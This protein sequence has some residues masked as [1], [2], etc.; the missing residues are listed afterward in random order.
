VLCAAPLLSSSLS[1]IDFC[2]TDPVQP[3][4]TPPQICT[5]TLAGK[6][7]VAPFQALSLDDINP[8][9]GV[10]YFGGSLVTLIGKRFH[11]DARLFVSGEEIFGV[12][13]TIPSAS[14][15]IDRIALCVVRCP[16]ICDH[17]DWFV[18]VPVRPAQSVTTLSFITVGNPNITKNQYVP[19]KVENPIPN[20]TTT[21]DYDIHNGLLYLTVQKCR[22]IDTSKNLYE[23]F[24]GR[25]CTACPTGAECAGDDRLWPMPGYW[26]PNERTPPSQCLVFEACPGA[27]GTYPEFPITYVSKYTAA[28]SSSLDAAPLTCTRAIPC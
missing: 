22:L 27:L 19:V 14:V 15:R 11:A 1:V 18:S 26:S 6:V 28:L 12:N 3:P 21:N 16:V 9:S 10:P 8:R 13:V 4:C 7:C 2:A 17:T 24:D 20:S 5:N 23:W 25:Q